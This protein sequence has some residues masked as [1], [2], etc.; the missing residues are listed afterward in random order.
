MLKV[1]ETMRASMFMP[2]GM[3]FLWQPGVLWRH[4]VSDTIIAASYYLIPIASIS[5]SSSSSTIRRY[6]KRRRASFA[7]SDCT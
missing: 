5:S 4:A 6:A 1:V 2:H 3:C 7:R